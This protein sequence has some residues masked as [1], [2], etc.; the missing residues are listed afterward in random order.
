MSAK[1]RGCCCEGTP[2]SP[3]CSTLYAKPIWDFNGGDNLGSI[4]F[5]GEAD[6]SSLNLNAQGVGN[7][8]RFVTSAGYTTVGAG[9]NPTYLASS[10]SLGGAITAGIPVVGPSSILTN[11][12][13]LRF[14]TCN[15]NWLPAKRFEY[16]GAGPDQVGSQS[17]RCGYHCKRFAVI[18]S[19]ELFP[20]ADSTHQ[21]PGVF[22]L[23]SKN[24]YP[25]Q[26]AS[27]YY[28]SAVK[29]TSWA[30]SWT[31][32]PF[33]VPSTTT[34]RWCSRVWLRP[35]TA[36]RYDGGAI[37]ISTPVIPNTSDGTDPVNGGH[38]PVYS[39]FFDLLSQD[40]GSGCPFNQTYQI[41]TTRNL[42]NY[43]GHVSAYR[44]FLDR[45][46]DTTYLIQPNTLCVRSFFD[47]SFNA[48]ILKPVGLPG[49]SPAPLPIFFA[50]QDIPRTCQWYP[51]TVAA[52]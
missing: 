39:L 42:T 26:S 25:P 28:A 20:G 15:T 23:T 27:E 4:H 17:V 24:P 52:G 48:Y 13:Q 32:E 10:T 21:T 43:R 33:R 2:L 7:Y 16:S 6:P 51:S 12:A 35:L 19:S 49:P 22:Q 50:V 1:Q 41:G 14:P 40:I 44:M 3:C 46:D 9:G 18:E 36:T 5:S 38:Q 34:L 11:F 29:V 31:I 30:I 47:S 37:N 8:S 45:P